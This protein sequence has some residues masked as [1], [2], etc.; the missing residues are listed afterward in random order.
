MLA[1]TLFFHDK[2]RTRLSRMLTLSLHILL[3]LKMQFWQRY[4]GFHKNNALGH[5]HKKAAAFITQ[6][7]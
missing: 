1:S 5:R 3:T 4:S 7:L 6:R 2:A